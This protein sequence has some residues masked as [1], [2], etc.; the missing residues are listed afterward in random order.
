MSGPLLLGVILGV[1]VLATLWAVFAYNGL[2]RASLQADE[3][4]STVAIQLKRRAALVPNLVETVAGYAAHERDTLAEVA[5]ARAGLQ[6]AAEPAAVAAA[7]TELVRALGRL[8][9][10]AEAYPDLKASGQ[11]QSLQGGLADLEAKIAFA[12]QFYNRAVLDLNSRVATL[13]SSIV[14]TA[15]RMKERPF[16]ELDEGGETPRVAFPRPPARAA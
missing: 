9:A 16:F 10:V 12:R 7:N 8:M 6:D 13:P 11:F 1:I 2:I 15:L 4:W 5:R 3:A 14:A